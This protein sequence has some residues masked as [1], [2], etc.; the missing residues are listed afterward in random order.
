M[1]EPTY[2]AAGN[3]KGDFTLSG[4]N[5]SLI[6]QDAVG[7]LSGNNEA[8]ELQRYSQSST[9][10]TTIEVL[11]DT[12]LLATQDSARPHSTPVYLGM[13]VSADR[14]TVFWINHTAPLP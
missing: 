3:V 4:V 8:P 7:I 2:Y 10:L 1:I 14:Q 9:W 13:I 11:D 5:F 12:H 6:P